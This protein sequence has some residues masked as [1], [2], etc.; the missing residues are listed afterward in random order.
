[1][2]LIKDDE[3]ETYDNKFIWKTKITN[4][5]KDTTDNSEEED[6]QIENR[7]STKIINNHVKNESQCLRDRN[8]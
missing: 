8:R 2:D 6:I 7:S 4:T 1:M 5:T 3:I